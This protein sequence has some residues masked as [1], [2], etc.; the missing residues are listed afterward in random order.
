[1]LKVL[2]IDLCDDGTCD[3]T[4]KSGEVVKLQM[5]SNEQPVAVAASELLKQ[6]RFLKKRHARQRIS[7]AAV[8][9]ASVRES[10]S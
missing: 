5:G 2:L 8:S 6:L 1:M 10:Q 7:E 9:E 3:V 4:G